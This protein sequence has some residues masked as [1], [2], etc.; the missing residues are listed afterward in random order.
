MNK[1]STYVLFIICCI[2]TESSLSAEW[3]GSAGLEQR[4]FLESPLDAS[5]HYGYASVVLRPEYYQS[6][7]E[8]RQSLTIAPFYRWDQY[9][10][11]RTHSDLRELYWLYIGESFEVSAGFRTIFWGTVETQHL[12][13]VINQID[14]VENPDGEEKLGQPMVATTFLTDWGN[15]ELYLMPYFRERTFPGE[16]GRLRTIPRV[17]TDEAALYENASRD[18]HVDLAFRWSKT[19]ASWDVGMSYF[20]GT[21]REPQLIPTINSSNESVLLP[22]YD[23]MHQFGL[24]VQ[25]VQG[26]W[27]WKLEAI[28]RDTQQTAYFAYTTGFEYTYYNVKYVG[29]DIGVVVEYSYDDRGI[30]A[31]TPFNNDLTLGIRLTPNDVH[32]TKVLLGAIL[33]CSSDGRIYTIESSR[34]LSNH[35]TLNIEATL[36]TDLPVTSP[37]YSYRQDDYIQL[38]LEYFF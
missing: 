12:V 37:Y 17:D 34:R 1:F 25:G 38:G 8:S 18:K 32:S 19:L 26:A 2:I 15:I 20:S 21:N 30:S 27:L 16:Q 9:D 6:W 29:M 5:Q 14:L 28:E 3:R 10:D 23:L 36:F 35:L 4:Q 33:D 22:F 31:T 13:D 11:N 7:D 24:D